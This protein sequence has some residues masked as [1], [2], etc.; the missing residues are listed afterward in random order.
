MSAVLE[1]GMRAVSVA[2]NAQTGNAGFLSPG[3]RVDLIVT[4]R[5]KHSNG[6]DESVVSETF[7]QDLRVVAVDQMLDNPEN[8]AILAKTVTIECN[9]HQAEQIAVA[10]EMG[11][12]SFT[13]RS[14]VR[15]QKKDPPAEEKT[16]A[17]VAPENKAPIE[18]LYG[19]A[20]ERSFT[21]D[22]DLS[23]LLERRVL[24][25]PRVQVIRGEKTE[26]IDFTLSQP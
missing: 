2:V 14:M 9:P 5:F 25:V 23:R 20:K 10:M 8:K 11:K 22:S 1:P 3:D 7:V 24:S 15:E 12:I 4:H 19:S 13:L 21:R 6:V 18:E 17:E 16:V 26:T